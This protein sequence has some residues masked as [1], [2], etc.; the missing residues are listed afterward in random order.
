MTNKMK[1]I[2]ARTQESLK[3]GIME[4]LNLSASEM[5]QIF[6]SIYEDTEKEPW[7]WVSDFLSDNMID[8]VLEHIQ[9]FHLSR[10]L[11]GTDPKKNNNLEQ[12]LLEDSP[13]SNFFKKY[14]ITFKPSK[15]HIDLYYKDELQSLDNEFRYDGRNVCY[16]KSRLGYYKNQDYCVNGFAF[17]SYLENNGYFSSL[18]SCPELVGNIESLLGIRGMVTDYYDNSKYYCIEYLIPMSD[19]IFDMGNPPETDYEKTVEFL[20]QAILRLYDEWVGS[21]FICDE[22]L[23]LRLSDDANIK[24]EWF[25]MAE[26]L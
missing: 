7:E 23:I 18:S 8:E 19:V 1:Y 26:E 22:N 9:M 16:I 15:G 5:I 13:L 2:D 21:S 14:K 12:L 24:P 25:V 11:E 10:R 4:F 3:Q 20:K 17:R 6:M